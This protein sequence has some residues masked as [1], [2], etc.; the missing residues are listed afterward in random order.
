MYL[1]NNN[2][3]NNWFILIIIIINLVSFF[4]LQPLNSLRLDAGLADIVPQYQTATGKSRRRRRVRR[5]VIWRFIITI[6]ARNRDEGVLVPCI[7]VE[8][9]LEN[10]A[11]QRF[12]KQ[13]AKR[14]RRKLRDKVR[15]FETYL[16]KH[17]EEREQLI[18]QYDEKIEEI[19]SKLPIST[20][21]LAAWRQIKVV[22]VFQYQYLRDMNL[23]LRLLL[24]T[25]C[26]SIIVLVLSI[27]MNQNDYFFMS[28][29][30]SASSLILG[31]SKIKNNHQEY[32][33][34]TEK[35][36]DSGY[37]PFLN[38]GWLVESNPSV[39]YPTVLDNLDWSLYN[40][41]AKK[42]QRKFSHFLAE[43]RKR[44]KESK[45]L[46]AYQAGGQIEMRLLFS[47]QELSNSFSAEGCPFELSEDELE[48]LE[49]LS[50]KKN[51][52]RKF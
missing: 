32:K 25:L 24:A 7:R 36:A 35:L 14:E 1:L 28:A 26:I 51:G 11:V 12:V 9:L 20:R 13:R 34:L 16:Q 47:P 19:K 5:I 39:L 3:R 46:K 10:K 45:K 49:R 48:E 42:Y 29:A 52:G 30:L 40:G 41:L 2:I 44:A 22:L 21:L 18:K 31:S 15:Q 17:A 37:Q 50:G 23:E 6:I 4:S 27:I 8:K 38:Y 43:A 33:Q